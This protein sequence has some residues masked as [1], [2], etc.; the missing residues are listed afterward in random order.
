[1]FRGGRA[2]LPRGAIGCLRFVIVVFPDHTHLLFLRSADKLR[3]FA[4][5]CNWSHAELRSVSYV[6]IH[7]LKFPINE[8]KY[9]VGT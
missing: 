9:I 2:A 6:I 8:Y 3:Y 1:M 4:N 5:L 7:F